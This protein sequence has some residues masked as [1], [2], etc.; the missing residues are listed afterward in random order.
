MDALNNCFEE[1]GIKGAVRNG[2]TGGG[3]IFTI[4]TDADME[5]ASEEAE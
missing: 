4:E 5:V 3:W 2:G 1:L